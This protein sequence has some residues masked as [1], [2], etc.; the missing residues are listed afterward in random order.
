MCR[1]I[2]LLYKPFINGK[3]IEQIEIILYTCMH[4][5]L[6]LLTFVWMH[7]STHSHTTTI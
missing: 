7:H 4:V 5:L 2:M 1:H 6:N 3:A